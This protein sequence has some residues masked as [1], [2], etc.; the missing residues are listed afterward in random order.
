METLIEPTGTRDRA[1]VYLAIEVD[2]APSA[3]LRTGVWE[4]AKHCSFVAAACATRHLSADTLK[5]ETTWPDAIV[6]RAGLGLVLANA[7]EADRC[8]VA[9]NV[10]F[11]RP[12]IGRMMPRSAT[13]HPHQWIDTMTLARSLNLPPALEELWR[14]LFPTQ[15]REQPVP[16]AHDRAALVRRRAAQVR[17]V[18]RVMRPH[19]AD[20]DLWLGT[21]DATINMRGIPVDTELARTR[22]AECAEA[23]D[24]LDT[25]ART[26][27]PRLVEHIP[28]APALTSP[29][30]VGGL[31]ASLRE[32]GQPQA[33]DELEANRTRYKQLSTARAKWDAVATTR[34]KRVRMSFCARGTTSGRWTA[35]GLQPQNLA[36]SDDPLLCTRAAVCAREGHTLISGDYG[37][38]EARLAMA[39]AGQPVEGGDVYQAV[40]DSLTG[41]TATK[42]TRDRVKA[43]MLG[44]QY[45][46]SKGKALQSLINA[47]ASDEDARAVYD[48][49]A[50][51]VNAYREQWARL[52]A[53]L[54]ERGHEMRFAGERPFAT[55]H[56]LP[57]TGRLLIWHDVR[58]QDWKRD[59]EVRKERVHSYWKVKTRQWLGEPIW[60]SKL[61]AHLVS[62]WAAEILA[63]A[64]V[65]F[66]SLEPADGAV[67][68]RIVLHAHDE[69]V[70][71][72][73]DVDVD[74]N[75]DLLRRTM[76]IP[77]ITPLPVSL[78]V[79]KRWSEMTPWVR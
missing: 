77:T 12:V 9:H 26:A 63:T 17:D 43:V 40:A 69:I 76:S 79:G 15:A 10:G 41:L 65:N 71:E 74:R 70:I 3:P 59:S 46:E 45:G 67:T 16:P 22:A 57:E 61:F 75:T 29:L 11:Y 64:I 73:P 38:I 53:H 1:C 37:Q 31:C 27:H 47:G 2:E 58:Q 68:A 48:T 4:F 35:Y 44:L 66:E 51:V 14:Y 13:P 24:T 5:A 72:S 21:I 33:A 49:M 56:R 50:P 25:W 7:V 6:D 19:V 18:Y 28:D 60:G 55:F 34:G 32:D 20:I 78:K 62:A 30:R 8:I 36:V 23:M 54:D 52:E 39:V 42:E